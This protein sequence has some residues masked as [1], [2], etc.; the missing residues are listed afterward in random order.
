MLNNGNGNPADVK[1]LK[2]AKLGLTVK[3]LKC[4]RLKSEQPGASSLSQCVEC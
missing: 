1:S 4:A 3:L 2:P